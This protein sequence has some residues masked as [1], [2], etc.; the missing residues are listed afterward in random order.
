MYIFISSVLSGFLSDTALTSPAD[1]IIDSRQAINIAAVETTA[2]GKIH[3]AKY[4]A[5]AEPPAEYKF[6]AATP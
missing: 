5:P 2:P 6:P 3:S 4:P 1:I